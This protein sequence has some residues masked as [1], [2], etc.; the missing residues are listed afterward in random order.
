MLH[1]EPCVRLLL[2]SLLLFLVKTDATLHSGVERRMSS[3]P[4][5]FAVGIAYDLAGGWIPRNIVRVPRPLGRVAASTRDVSL[6]R[7]QASTRSEGD[8]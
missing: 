1:K 5:F 4:I 2:V 8:N 7:A 3:A 6:V